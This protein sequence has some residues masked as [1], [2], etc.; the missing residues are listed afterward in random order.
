MTIEHRNS[1]IT[2]SLAEYLG[3]I[4][5]KTLITNNLA[6]NVLAIVMAL[7]KTPTE[8]SEKSTEQSILSGNT[9]PFSYTTHTGFCDL[10]ISFSATRSTLYLLSLCSIWFEIRIRFT[11]SFSEAA[12]I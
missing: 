5:S 3:S 12:T 4:G 7:F 6:L 11:F 8:A 10:R 2:F 9:L 1:R